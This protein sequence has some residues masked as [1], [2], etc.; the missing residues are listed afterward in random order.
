M[1][2]DTKQLKTIS[3]LYVE[4]DDII[5]NQTYTLFEKIFKKV[6]IA[7]DGESGLKIYSEEKEN[8]DIIV[9]D[10]N[11]PKVN[12]LDM[13]KNINLIESTPIPK[14][15]TTAHTDSENL[16]TAMSHDVDKYITKPI[17]VKELTVNIVNLVLKYR[18]SNKLESLAKD[19]AIK[20]NQEN[21]KNQKLS[22][23]LNIKTKENELYKTIINDY[24][25][26]FETDKNGIILE[27]TPKFNR[28]FEYTEDEIIGEN[29]NR[30]KCPTCTQESLQKLMLRAIHSKQ[31][32]TTTQTFTK[33]SGI[34][35]I[36]DVTMTPN[37]GS[38][39]LVSGYTFYLDIT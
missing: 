29:I 10:I 35:I 36:C 12:G 20:S 26:K 33:S 39:F 9:T 32:V 27:V 8:I 28:L 23:L 13:I 34:S 17:Q 25:S 14:I 2:L 7:E 19:L 38:N 37:Y 30:L 15:V 21:K 16:L 1:K 3:L 24:V 18:R 11:M 22:Y 4:D 31:T 5:R 6:Y